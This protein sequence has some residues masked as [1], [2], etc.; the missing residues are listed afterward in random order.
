MINQ[1]GENNNQLE[2]EH[3]PMAQLVL[4]SKKV[5]LDEVIHVFSKALLTYFHGWLLMLAQY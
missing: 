3:T 4:G 1:R 5:V 2:G